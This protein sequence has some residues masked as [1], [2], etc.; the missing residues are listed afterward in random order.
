MLTKYKVVAL[1]VFEMMGAK[2]YSTKYNAT[3]KGADAQFHFTMAHWKIGK[4]DDRRLL[5]DTIVVNLTNIRVYVLLIF[6]MPQCLP[7]RREVETDMF[8]S[9]VKKICLS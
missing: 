5:A 2:I 8:T 7:K 3:L 4:G 9:K 1:P 6:R